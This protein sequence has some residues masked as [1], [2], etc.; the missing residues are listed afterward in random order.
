VTLAGLESRLKDRG[1]LLAL[2]AAATVAVALTAL[3]QQATG[4][5]GWDLAA[6]LYKL[7][8]L[9]EGWG[10]LWDTYWYGGSYGAIAYGPLYYLLAL[11][12]PWPI[13]VVLSAGAIPPLFLLYYRTAWGVDDVWP[14]WVLAGVLCL[15]LA[16]GQDPFLLALAL[17]L[18]GMALQAGGRPLWAALPVGLGIFTNP[19]ALVVGAVFL[20]GD[21]VARPGSRRRLLVFAAALLPFL[22]A[23]LLLGLVFTEPSWYLDQLLQAL[24]YTSFAIVG[25][26]LALVNRAHPRRPF[27]L[28]LALY[29]LAVLLTTIIPGNPLGNNVGRFFGVFALPVLFFLR[30]DRFRRPLGTRWLPWALLPI[31]GF[32]AIQLSAPISHFFTYREDLPATTRSFFEP[33]LAAAARYADPDHRLHVVAPRRHFEALYLPEAGFAITRGWYRQADALHNDIFYR[34][35]GEAGYVTW[36]RSMGVEYVLCPDAPLDPWSQREPGILSGSARFQ[37]IERAGAWSVYRLREAEGLV[38][39]LDGGRGA[40]LS[41]DH[42]VFRLRIDRPGRYL[43][44]VT[45]TPFWRLEGLRGR[46]AATGDGFVVLHADEAGQGTL[47]FDVTAEAVL[48]ELWP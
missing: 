13:V 35:Y 42:L 41:S 12:V 21:F 23:R 36:L 40:V 15:Y 3:A 26:A 47:R 31:A 37:R 43:V 32:A 39:G 8:L 33:A 38:R 34:G 22:V 19:L 4:T 46:L 5:P 20:V 1:G 17:T 6:H 18:G 10:V 9:R 11:A 29:A 27:F 2:W 45:S 25:A 44:K 7:H 16:H 28:L 48:G 30:N 14:A 24:L